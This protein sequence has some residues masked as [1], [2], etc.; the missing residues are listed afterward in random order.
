M[1]FGTAHLLGYEAP[2]AEPLYRFADFNAGQYAS[3]NAAFQA[4]VSRLSGTSLVLDGDLLPPGAKEGTIGETER[5]VAG[6]RTAAGP[7]RCGHPE[8]SRAGRQ[9]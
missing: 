1:Y 4:A 3:R 8:R 9:G 6:A 5:A 2:Y 7:R